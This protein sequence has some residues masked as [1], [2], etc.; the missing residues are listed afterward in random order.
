MF[1]RRKG[2]ALLFIGALCVLVW[3]SFANA[4]TR[5]NGTLNIMGFGTGDDVATTRA[6]IAIKA[7]APDKINNPNGGFNDQQF[8]AAVAGGN[9]PDLVYMDR[10]DV[11]TYAAKGVLMPLTSCIKSQNIKMSQYRQ[12]A[13]AE[14]SYKG[15]VYGIPEF[16]NART[17]IVNRLIVQKA[18]LKLS[19][20]S[21]T[22][23]TKLAQ[24]AKKMS[25]VKNGKVVRI[26]FDPKLP[27]FLPLW[28]KAN[29]QDL[30]S[31]DGT[32]AFLNAPKTVQALKFALSLINEQGGWN[33]FSSFRNTFDFFGNGNQYAKNQLGAFPMEDWYYNVLAQT[34][35]QIRI[36]SVPFTNRKG[37][38]INYEGGSTWVIP[39][40]AKNPTAACT[41]AKTMT[42]PSTWM[43]A[44]KERAAK[45]AKAN[46]PFTG[47]FTANAVADQEIYNKVFKASPK[48]KEWDA[49]YKNL[50]F[51]QRYSFGIPVSP[52]GEEVKNAWMNAVNRVLQGQ[53][54]PQDALNQAQK[55]ATSAINAAK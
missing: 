6:A 44:A 11:G 41:W 9:A 5:D 50:L 23:W 38:V 19:D 45:V 16:E 15:A 7:V 33:A 31:K 52:A 40:A 12:A 22:N 32:K 49:A 17:L 4:H 42:A 30:M 46:Q 54:S 26:G 21:T 20:I 10:Q 47:L 35:P 53:Q 51:V 18:G 14:V 48:F 25:V 2:F 24:V 13:V 29:G 39:K 27:E 28:A 36:A 3:A 34:S 55:E 1:S 37:A 8:L 43:A